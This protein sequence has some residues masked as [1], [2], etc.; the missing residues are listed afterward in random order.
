VSERVGG[1]D[2]DVT[3]RRALPVAYG[4]SSSHRQPFLS[5]PGGLIYFYIAFIPDFSVSCVLES[6]L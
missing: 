2:A 6:P 1:N 5:S 4:E 3:D